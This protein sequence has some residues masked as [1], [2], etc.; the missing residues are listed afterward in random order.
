MYSPKSVGAVA[1][2]CM[3]S[4]DLLLI[5]AYVFD[6]RHVRLA[7]PHLDQLL[8]SRSAVS[9]FA[10]CVQR[11]NHVAPY[12]PS[13]SMRMPFMLMRKELNADAALSNVVGMVDDRPFLSF[14]EL[15]SPR[16]SGLQLRLGLPSLSVPGRRTDRR[17]S[18]ICEIKSGEGSSS[19]S[20]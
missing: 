7:I 2:T 18:D 5:G 16:H 13:A 17:R 20:H 12:S 14:S 6:E 11:R 4:S 19:S 9:T 10:I 1:L 15:G 3:Y 8:D